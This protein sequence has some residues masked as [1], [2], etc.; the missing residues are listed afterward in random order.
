MH[1]ELLILKTYSLKSLIVLYLVSWEN[2]DMGTRHVLDVL[3][4]S[5][6][7]SLPLYIID[8]IMI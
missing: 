4:Y 8:I 5:T 3:Q 2:M 1:T 6:E 7:N